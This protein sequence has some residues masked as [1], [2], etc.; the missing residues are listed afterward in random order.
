MQKMLNPLE[1]RSHLNTYKFLSYLYENKK[2][3][4]SFND[5]DGNK[6]HLF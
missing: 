6:S 3:P 5:N 1:H 2:F 4:L